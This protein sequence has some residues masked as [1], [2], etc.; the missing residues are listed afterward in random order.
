MERSRGAP[1]PATWAIRLITLCA[2]FGRSLFGLLLGERDRRVAAAVILAMQ[3]ADWLRDAS[4]SYI[5]AFALAAVAQLLAA[6]VILGGR[7][8][9]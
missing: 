1:R 9:S 7:R 8:I 4:D 3:A 5:M 6:A 2:V